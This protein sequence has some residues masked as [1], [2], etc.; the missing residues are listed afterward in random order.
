MLG[1]LISQSLEC[2]L[3]KTQF[4]KVLEAKVKECTSTKPPSSGDDLTELQW[5]HLQHLV[6]DEIDSTSTRIEDD[7]DVSDLQS[8]GL[9]G[10]QRV[11]SSSLRL[12]DHAQVLAETCHLSSADRGMLCRI[13]PNGRDCE[14]VLNGS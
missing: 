12:T 11:H 9:H 3:S 2:A 7:V 1:L 4:D 8:A 5:F 10:G 14:D 6:G 13:R